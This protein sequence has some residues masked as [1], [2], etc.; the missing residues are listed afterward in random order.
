M[1]KSAIKNY[2]VWARR[3]LLEAVKQRA[4]EFEITDSDPDL[5]HVSGHPLTD[6]EKAQRRQLIAEIQERGY[7]TVMEEAAYTW[8]N[9]FIALRFM[10]VNGYLPSKVRVFTDENGEFKPDIL[11]QALNWNWMD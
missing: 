8:F 5:E 10:E 4:F 1:N 9:R 6:A 3:K 11:T 7:D 2:A